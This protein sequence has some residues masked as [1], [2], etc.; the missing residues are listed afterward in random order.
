MQSQVLK[1]GRESYRESYFILP[2]KK[3]PAVRLPRR[4][5]MTGVLTLIAVL[6]MVGIALSLGMWWDSITVLSN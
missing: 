5:L 3:Q 1:S 4:P 6:A 2:T